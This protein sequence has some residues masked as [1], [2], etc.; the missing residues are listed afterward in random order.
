[1]ALRD[2]S[3]TRAAQYGALSGAMRRFLSRD[4]RERFFVD[5]AS[6]PTTNATPTLIWAGTVPYTPQDILRFKHLGF[7]NG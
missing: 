3:L 2:R 5:P 4:R 6:F 1:M 7:L